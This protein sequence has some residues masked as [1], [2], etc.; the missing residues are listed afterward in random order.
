MNPVDNERETLFERGTLVRKSSRA[1][2]P[3]IVH[4][5][6]RR[7]A[8]GPLFLSEKRA[9]ERHGD[10]RAGKSDVSTSLEISTRYTR[11]RCRM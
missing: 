1:R 8:K 10:Y 9:R 11:Q 7:S 5:V 6:R 2:Y 3:I 4:F